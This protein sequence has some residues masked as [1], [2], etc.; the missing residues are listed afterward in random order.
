MIKFKQNQL[1]T[2][3]KSIFYKSLHNGIRYVHNMKARQIF[4]GMLD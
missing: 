4:I 1:S 3:V 2:H